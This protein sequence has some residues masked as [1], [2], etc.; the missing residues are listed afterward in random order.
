MKYEANKLC[1]TLSRIRRKKQIPKILRV[2][3]N[4]QEIENT[5]TQIQKY[6]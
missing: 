3:N 5:L 2:E 6:S 1:K 4:Q